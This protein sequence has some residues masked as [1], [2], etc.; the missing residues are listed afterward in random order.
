MLRI[1]CICALALFATL[2]SAVELKL[3]EA[4]INKAGSML[5]ISAD[6]KQSDASS[7]A[8]AIAAGGQFTKAL[9]QE[10]HA[11][12]VTIYTKE[13]MHVIGDPKKYHTGPHFGV[14][15]DKGQTLSMGILYA[16][17]LAGDKTYT[18]SSFDR[19]ENGGS[20]FAN[21]QYVGVQRKAGWN[22]WTFSVD[23]QGNPSVS[24]NDSVI[25][26]VNTKK[27]KFNGIKGIFVKGD[28]KNGEH[29]FFIDT[30]SYELGKQLEP[31]KE[32]PLTPE[33]D[34]EIEATVAIV[35][36]L[37]GKHPRLLFTAEDIPAI[38]AL[39]KNEGSFF[40]ER[41]SGYAP[42]CVTPNHTKFQ[43]DATDGQRQG[44]WRLPTICM[45]WVVTEDPKSLAEA[46]KFLKFLIELDQWEKGSEHDCGMSSANIM[47]G[48]ALAYDILYHELDPA[49]REQ[50]RKKLLLMARR[51]YYHGHMGL[52]KSVQYW[53]G[54]PA[55]NHRWHRNAGMVLATLAAA[56]DV[57]GN[58]DYQWILEMCKKD[59][60]YVNKW[61]PA[62]GTSH[63]SPSYL[64]FGLTHLCLF[65]D[66]ADRCLGTTYQKHSAFKNFPY[67]RLYTM[68]QGM[69]KTFAYGDSGEGAIGGYNH[70]FFF[71]TRAHQDQV[72]Q[73]GIEAFMKKHPKAFDFGWFGLVWYDRTLAGGD[74]KQ[75]PHNKFFEDMGLSFMRD[76][77]DLTDTSASMMLKCG[78]YG[79]YDLNKFRNQNNFKYVNI[80]HDDPDANEII[81]FARG[82]VFAKPDGYSERKKTPGPQ[83]SDRQRQRSGCLKRP[84]VDPTTG[85]CRF[86]EI[87]LHHH[88]Q[89]RRRQSHL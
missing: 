38:R 55:N 8:V 3:D 34:P 88:L 14:Y 49:F 87:I 47:I 6:E 50:A 7:G 69:K 54:D 24:L 68:T 82:K 58:N 53:Q 89:R 71:C 1:L 76:S 10:I 77:W 9:S 30:I 65:T 39:A 33:Q 56:D 79:G 81:L 42:V 18:F 27:V 23:E 2:A 70:A 11:G 60:D 51:Q 61:L 86:N 25:D 29:S 36:S 15:D 22:K 13:N 48:A 57:D 32:A 59:M 16:K 43:R 74:H 64:V 73:A 41:V 37:K 4:L 67:F 78:P 12:S 84:N 26:R 35:D 46:K 75:L 72:A 19:G 40:M 31:K 17:Y 66:A 20:P 45:H 62:D 80:A 63:E 83:Y 52:A 28:S 44:L 85:Q 21:I 5:S